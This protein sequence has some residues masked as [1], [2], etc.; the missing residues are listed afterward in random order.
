MT[1]H[2]PESEGITLR[3]DELEVVVLPGKGADIYSIIDLASGIDVL[4]KTPWGWQDPQRLPS[5]ADSQ[6]DWLARY[7][8]GWQQLL[9]NAGAPRE[10]AGVLRGYHGEAAVTG[11]RA[12]FVTTSI[13]ELETTLVTAPLALTRK[14]EVSGPAVRV[15]DT[16]RNESP[17]PVPVMWVQHPA[18]GAPFID[19]R[20]VISAG[21]RRIVS[22]AEAPG[23]VLPNDQSCGFPKGVGRAGEPVDLGRAPAA[24][25]ASAT[26]AALTDFDAGWFAIDSPTAGFGIRVEWDLACF[27]HAWFWQECNATKNF[28]WY[29]RAYVVAVEPA[30]TLPGE[31]SP[32][33]PER[34]QAPLI[35]GDETWTS[36]ITFSR[37]ALRADAPATPIHA[38]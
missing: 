20:A 11:W 16:V 10:V 14:V 23:T 33:L 36:T 28:P 18:F 1:A 6:L 8:G 30:N 2:P 29:R 32:A 27:P 35:T 13:A 4:F 5:T 24:G 22:D 31:P 21:A 9:P 19:D 37:T 34:G 15:R 12:V 3:S 26:F 38:Q 7:A 17:D 25:S